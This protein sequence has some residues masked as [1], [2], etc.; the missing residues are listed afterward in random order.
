MA[1]TVPVIVRDLLTEGNYWV[2][3]PSGDGIRWVRWSLRWV[4]VDTPHAKLI[5][6]IGNVDIGVVRP[7]KWQTLARASGTNGTI[8]ESAIQGWS[9]IIANTDDEYV[10]WD[11]P[12]GHNRIHVIIYANAS[13]GTWNITNG[14]SGTDGYDVTSIDLETT[15]FP[16]AS[17]A[18]I[19]I[20][21]NMSGTGNK[22]RMTADTTNGDC[23]MYGIHSFNTNEIGD[24]STVNVGDSL[25]EGHD[26]VDMYDP[27]GATYPST[28]FMNRIAVAGESVLIMAQ[29]TLEFTVRWAPDGE[30]TKWT[31]YSSSHFGS[32][33]ADFVTRMKKL[34]IT[35]VTAADPAVVTSNGH[36]LANGDTVVITDV[37]GN[38]GDDVLNGNE[39][40]VA[41]ADAN[42]FQLDSTDTI[43]KTYTSGGIAS[44]SS[45]GPE[46]WINGASQ[47]DMTNVT[48]IPLGE[49]HADGRMAIHVYGYSNWDEDAA[50]PA[51]SS[52]DL[53][54]I[55][56]IQQFTSSGFGFS[57]ELNWTGDCD[58]T[59]AYIPS[60]P[61][62]IEPVIVVFP[63]DTVEY[64]STLGSS[65][66]SQE[67]NIASMRLEQQ[68]VRIESTG[69]GPIFKILDTSGAGSDKMLFQ[70]DL[71]HMPG[72]TN[73]NDK[74][75]VLGGTVSV[76]NYAPIRNLRTRQRYNRPIWQ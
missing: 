25:S 57:V 23:V 31:A 37:V 5:Y 33:E 14:A 4:G 6:H 22:L 24:P 8:T 34:V 18:E 42:T 53:L 2:F 69:T 58:V 62:E 10:E 55:A 43:G 21:T 36:G 46:L 19:V 11:I 68:Y 60:V 17:P 35:D 61:M 70:V 1:L 3:T 52:Q 38:M 66:Y 48:D 29:N 45:L 72:R 76:Q 50:P 51:Q 30:T 32:G 64:L 15:G 12:D 75:W 40:T 54:E 41:G 65:D 74:R 7:G 56:M 28:F 59:T 47:G 71:D 9:K 67:N 20:A 13:L 73:P 44:S 16:G 26:L 27:T 39:F 63:P 49:I